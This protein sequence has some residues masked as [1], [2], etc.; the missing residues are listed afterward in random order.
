MLDPIK[1]CRHTGI[2]AFAQLE[3]VELTGL[4]GSCRP[5]NVQIH[6]MF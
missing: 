1:G 4:T 2:I 6:S 5:V 3:E